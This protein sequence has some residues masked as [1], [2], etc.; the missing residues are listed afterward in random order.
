MTTSLARLPTFAGATTLDAFDAVLKHL[1]TVHPSR[2]IKLV[3]G[4][5]A[6]GFTGV[7]ELHNQTDALRF[8][9]FVDRLYDA[10]VRIVASGIPLDRGLPRKTCSPAAT[11]RST[12]ARSP[13]LIALTTARTAVD[14]AATLRARTA[15]Q[16]S[17]SA[18]DRSRRAIERDAARR[19]SLRS[20]APPSLRRRAR[21]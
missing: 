15:P 16:A 6:V 3:D 18:A 2:Y 5:A 10:Q 13:A 12:C 17:S 9:A 21:S 14:R 8:V 19:G 4:L 7:H 20:R 11:A 1:G